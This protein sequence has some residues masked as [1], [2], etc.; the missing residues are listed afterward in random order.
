MGEREQRLNGRNGSRMGGVGEMEQRWNGRGAEREQRGGREGAVGE[1][2]GTAVL[3]AWVSKDT[4]S[5][6]SNQLVRLQKVMGWCAAQCKILL[7][8]H[9]YL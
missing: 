4:P 1:G 7:S 5:G 6:S 8:T 2:G 9:L 3:G